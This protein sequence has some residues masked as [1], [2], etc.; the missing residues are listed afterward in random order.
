MG[1]QYAVN[2]VPED[3]VFLKVKGDFAVY[4]RIVGGSITVLSMEILAQFI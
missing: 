4:V 3:A 1:E 2:S